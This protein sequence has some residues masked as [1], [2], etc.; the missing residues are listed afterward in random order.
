[1]SLEADIAREAMNDI[2]DQLRDIGLPEHGS[3]RIEPVKAWMSKPGLEAMQLA[4]GSS[5]DAV[6]WADVTQQA[7]RDSELNWTF[8]ADAGNTHRRHRDRSGLPDPR[9]R[10]D[11]AG[12]RVRR[13]HQHSALHWYADARIFSS[14]RDSNPG[15]GV[16]HCDRPDHGHG[17]CDSSARL[18]EPRMTSPR[19]CHLHPGQV[20]VHRR[21][22]RGSGGSVVPDISTGSVACPASSSQRRQ[23][24]QG[25]VTLVAF[26]VGHDVWWSSMQLLLNLSRMAMA[27]GRRSRCSRWC[28]A[29]LESPSASWRR[30]S[31]SKRSHEE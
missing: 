24:L 28:G 16:R 22:H 21:R 10:G 31:R 15:S 4:P 29:G 20:V 2:V 12:S 9:D 27:G 17:S 25:N 5:A 19:D 13:N 6:V 26:G 18:G 8:F 1:M 30:L 3:V 7:Y 14:S 23:S 11:G